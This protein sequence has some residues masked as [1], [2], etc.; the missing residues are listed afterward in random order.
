MLLRFETLKL[1]DKGFFLRYLL[2]FRH[3]QFLRF[4]SFLLGCH[5][6]YLVLL[7]WL[8]LLDYCSGIRNEHA[9]GNHDI[10][11]FILNDIY[12]CSYRIIVLRNYVWLWNI[13]GEEI[14]LRFVRL[15]LH[16]YWRKFYTL[17]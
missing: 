15:L 17:K 3:G 12:I 5:F 10:F 4:L 8:F 13:K 7:F 2:L 16:Y 6:V 11:I 1:F 14:V 9:L